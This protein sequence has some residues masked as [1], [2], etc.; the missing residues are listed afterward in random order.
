MENIVTHYGRSKVALILNCIANAFY[1]FEYLL[2]V[3]TFKKPLTSNYSIFLES[4][5]FKMGA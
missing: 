3:L 2:M 1:F 5:I 4:D